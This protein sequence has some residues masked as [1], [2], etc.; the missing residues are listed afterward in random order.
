MF[1]VQR[2]YIDRNLLIPFF[3]LKI[4]FLKLISWLNRLNKFNKHILYISQ[5]MFVISN[6]NKTKKYSFSYFLNLHDIIV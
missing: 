3:S 6:M 1:T 5:E 2:N 4:N